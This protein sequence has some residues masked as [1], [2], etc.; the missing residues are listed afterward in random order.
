M[1][2]QNDEGFLRFVWAKQDQVHRFLK[3][4]M[5][6]LKQEE[7]E[8]VVQDTYAAALRHANSLDAKTESGVVTWL[9][10]VARRKVIDNVRVDKA[11]KRR[12][13]GRKIALESMNLAAKGRSPSSVAAIIEGKRI[14][15]AAMEELPPHYRVA[16]E[17]RYLERLPHEETGR[18]LSISAKAAQM[19][20]H[21]ALAKLKAIIGKE[22]RVL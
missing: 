19:L 14:L 4:R 11:Q 16:I 1:A 2:L 9:C 21:R 3:S 8:D 10:T 15:E 22:S 20:T 6:G 5:P 13:R 7:A 12:G 18:R 17:T